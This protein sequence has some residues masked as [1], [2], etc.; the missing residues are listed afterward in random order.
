MMEYHAVVGRMYF[1]FQW[2]LIIFQYAVYIEHSLILNNV[3]NVFK[4]VIIKF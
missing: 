4:I 1:V 2:I 3:N